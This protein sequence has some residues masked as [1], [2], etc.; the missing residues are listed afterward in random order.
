MLASFSVTGLTFAD[1]T[2]VDAGFKATVPA[3]FNGQ[4]YVVL[5]ACKDK[6]IGDDTIIAGPAIMEITNPYPSVFKS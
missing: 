2:P 6:A 5:T 3:G 1:A 4:G